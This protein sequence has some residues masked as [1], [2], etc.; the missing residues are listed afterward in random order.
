LGL[1]RELFVVRYYQSI[2][3]KRAL[4]GSG[5]TLGISCLDLVVVARLALD[6]DVLMIVG[7]TIGEAIGTYVGIK[8]K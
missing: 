6:K 2:P 7:Y 4:L 5:L 8:R 1:G 3:Q